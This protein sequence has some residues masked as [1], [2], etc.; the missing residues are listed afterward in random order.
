MSWH[1]FGK[2]QTSSE[3]TDVF[4]IPWL[5]AKLHEGIKEVSSREGSSQ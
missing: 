5:P 2:G 1:S 3:F 4:P